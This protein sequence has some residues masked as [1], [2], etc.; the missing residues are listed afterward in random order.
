MLPVLMTEGALTLM[1]N[2]HG[3]GIYGRQQLYRQCAELYGGCH[4]AEPRA[5]N[6]ELLRLPAVVGGHFNTH[7]FAADMA[8][9]RV[10]HTK[11][12]YAKAYQYK[13]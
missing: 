10:R 1:A 6:A 2:F 11:G 4:C 5:E 3:L 12:I 13:I 9:S 8:V 7:L